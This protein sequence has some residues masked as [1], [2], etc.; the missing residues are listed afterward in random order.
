MAPHCTKNFHH[1]L[2][3]CSSVRGR[4]GS[5]RKPASRSAVRRAFTAARVSGVTGTRPSSSKK[6]IVFV[7]SSSRLGARSAIGGLT[8][9]LASCPLSVRN[10]SATSAIVRA[11]G[12]IAPRIEN[13]PTHGGRWPRPGM[14]P[15]VGLSEQMPVKCAGTR[16][17]P[18]LSLPSPAADMPAAMRRRLASAR[19]ARRAL[20]VPWIRRA[21]VQQIRRFVRHQE[22][23]AIGRA[24]NQ[25]SRRAQPRHHHR[26]F[27]RNL[28]LVQQAADLALD[29]P[30]WRSTTSR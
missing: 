11:M 16:T 30:R 8:G 2:R 22:L 19:S 20:Q 6:P 12:P 21:P 18:P 24:Q 29:I 3:S 28:A 4:N 13:G 26:I 25:R 10:N 1:S 9:S 27:A 7:R 5:T 17:E 15:G 23:R 14:R